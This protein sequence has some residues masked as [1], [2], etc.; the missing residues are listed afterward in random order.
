MYWRRSD[1]EPA[2]AE[3]RCWISERN[4]LPPLLPEILRFSCSTGVEEFILIFT[5]ILFIADNNMIIANELVV[6]LLATNAC[7]YRR[8]CAIGH[9][10]LFLMR[11]YCQVFHAAMIS[12][13]PSS[14]SASFASAFKYS[15]PKS[16]PDS[17][18]IIT[19]E[20]IYDFL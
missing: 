3:F 12:R 6:S 13:P 9:R 11:R 2:N 20:T 5:L 7:S 1:S 16:Y 19:P 4:Y 18:I 8:L 15:S 14:P 10:L 17:A